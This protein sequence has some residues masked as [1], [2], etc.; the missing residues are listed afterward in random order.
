MRLDKYL[1]DLGIG[2][3]KEI[4]KLIQAGLVSVDD[5]IITKPDFKVTESS[6]V[7]LEGEPLVYQQY[8]YFLLNKPAGYICTK[9]GSPNVLELVPNYYKDLNPVGRLDKETEGL[10]IIT[11]DGQLT[12]Q[13]ISPK[14]HVDKK[15]YFECDAPLPAEAKL[16]LSQPIEFSDFTSLP[17]KLEQLTDTS[18]YLTIHEGKFHQV[19]RMIGYLGSTVTY[20]KRT[21]Y[22]FL[23]IEDLNVGE[24]REL[25]QEEIEKLKG[26]SDNE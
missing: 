16:I 22:S 24:Y 6:Y 26:G 19:R 9:D 8:Q 12:H 3:R 5:E 25:T 4:K 23:N 20:L 7:T 11:N 13:L 14:Y 18:G 2:T 10:L 1:A 21:E 17:G 15:Y